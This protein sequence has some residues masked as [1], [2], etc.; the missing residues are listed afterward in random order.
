M[1]DISLSTAH[2]WTIENHFTIKTIE[3]ILQSTTRSYSAPCLDKAMN[4]NSDK[5]K[6]FTFLRLLWESLILAPKGADWAGM[7][8]RAEAGSLP[9]VLLMLS[10][11]TWGTACPTCSYGFSFNFYFNIGLNAIVLLK[12]DGEKQPNIIK[13][14]GRKEW[15]RLMTNRILH[16]LYLE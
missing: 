16:P 11:L 7:T 10:Q 13:Q 2:Y 6:L 4:G 14:K 9:A 8:H 5:S 15:A 1:T 3:I 12:S